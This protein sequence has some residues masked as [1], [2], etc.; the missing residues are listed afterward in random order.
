MQR[1]PE[2]L[3]RRWTPFGLL[4]SHSRCHGAFP[5][6]PWNY[7]EDFMNTFR[8]SVSLKYRLMPYVYGQ[9]A[10][11][12]RDGLP[13]LRTLFLEFPEDR[14]AWFIEDQ[15]MF[16][17]NLLVAPLLKKLRHEMCT[18][19][20]VPGST[21]RQAEHILAGCGT[22]LRLARFPALS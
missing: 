5:R 15:Y 22:E 9:A 3:Y 12:S 20:R 19:Q 10:T 8:K 7:S 2:K 16:G 21:I 17:S 13:M 11:C 6:E 1:S 14:T 4:S 18:C